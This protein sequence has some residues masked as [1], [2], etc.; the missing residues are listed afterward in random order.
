ME[1]FA[2]LFCFISWA[3][4]RCRDEE[5]QMTWY[6]IFRVWRLNDVLQFDE[7]DACLCE[8]SMDAMR[9]AKQRYRLAS[10]ETLRAEACL[11]TQHINRAK[12][13]H[14]QHALDDHIANWSDADWKDFCDVPTYSGDQDKYERTRTR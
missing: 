8:C 7:L 2:W 5:K 11:T 10:G 14:N 4:W 12:V 6:I 3:V 13:L 9:Y 1:A